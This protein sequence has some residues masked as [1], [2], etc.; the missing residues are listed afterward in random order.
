MPRYVR[1]E[2]PARRRWTSSEAEDPQCRS[3]CE[4]IAD[5]ILAGLE[6]VGEVTL[7]HF[8]FS[9]PMRASVRLP[10]RD[11]R[12]FFPRPIWTVE[13]VLAQL[14]RVRATIM[15]GVELEATGWLT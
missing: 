12:V 1:Y 13:D 5:A 4:P 9:A 15:R 10:D 8:P 7:L 2:N 14:P 11:L 6:G 3:H